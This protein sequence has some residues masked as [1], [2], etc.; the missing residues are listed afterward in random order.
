MNKHS[1]LIPERVPKKLDYVTWVEHTSKEH[2]WEL[3]EGVPFSLDGQE[4]DLLALCLIYS[5][6]LEHM[7]KE[8]LPKQSKIELLHLLNKE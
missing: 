2:K 6:G 8:L 5:M 4:R 3:W 7:V 1:R